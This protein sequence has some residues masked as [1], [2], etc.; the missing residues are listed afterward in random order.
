MLVVIKV[1]FQNQFNL[2]WLLDL[3]AINC[4]MILLSIFEIWTFSD[5]IGLKFWTIELGIQGS[6]FY[7]WPQEIGFK[8]S[9]C[10]LKLW[11][12]F[13]WQ[14]LGYISMSLNKANNKP[15]ITNLSFAIM[16]EF[17]RKNVQGNSY[18]VL[19]QSVVTSISELDISLYWMLAMTDVVEQLETNI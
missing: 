2:V 17:L 8:L 1:E 19:N 16:E 12:I 15:D 14:C 18:D 4:S 7:K 11:I 9:S 6:S 13:E 5:N 10:F 3:R